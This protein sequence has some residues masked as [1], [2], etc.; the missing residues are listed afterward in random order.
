MKSA[1]EVLRREAETLIEP[2]ETVEAV[3][4]KSPTSSPTTDR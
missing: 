4:T 2:N 1:L 3:E